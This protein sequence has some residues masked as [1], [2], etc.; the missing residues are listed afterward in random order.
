M[1]EETLAPEGWRLQRVGDCLKLQNGHAFKPTDWS[2][3]GDP[4]IRIQNLN[5]PT[6]PYNHFA[7]ELP[8]RFRARAGDLLFAWSGTPG[9]SFGAHVWTGG[10]AWINQHIFRVDF[11]EH[12][13]D[14]DF[15]RLALN[16]N[17]GA[18][19]AGAQ[20]G[21]G[22]AHIT[23]AKLNDSL[24]LTPPLEDQRLIAGLI[25]RV[26]SSKR[27][28]MSHVEAGRAAVGRFRQAIVA[29]ACSGR[30]TADWRDAHCKAAPAV[31]DSY[32]ATWEET[33]LDALAE[34]IRGGSTE[35]PSNDPTAYPVLRSS[36][37]RSFT[38]DYSDVRFLTES[39][40]RRDDNF[41]TEGDLLI[42]RLSGSI[43]YVGNCAV[44]R[45]LHG[46][47]IQYPDRL[48]RC[49]L[50][51][52]GEAG[53][54]ELAFAGPQ[55]RAQLENA[56]RSAA[57][58]QRVSISDLKKLRI[59]RAPLD[60]QRLIVERSRRLLGMADVISTRVDGAHK[61]I[62]RS[63]RALLAKAFRGELAVATSSGDV[64]D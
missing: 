23:K 58:H 7:G 2:E 28:A 43:S 54:V 56:S 38:V 53:F 36:S 63:S 37:V 52:P 51:E 17:L 11:S 5:S 19:I 46:R 9:T 21:V 29:A 60:E 6:A 1:S 16:F 44:V 48:F 20:G 61:Q 22:L 30:L 41:L 49:R 18:Y 42:T 3:A 45:G 24:L 26:E 10:N 47:R 8:E 50:K 14:R 31:E 15:L 57:G 35:V 59:P 12:S 39:Q 32:P 13:Y 33:T 27:S 34:S 4:I 55:V 25:G 62:E 40:S 64:S